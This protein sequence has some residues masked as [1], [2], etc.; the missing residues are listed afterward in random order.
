MPYDKPRNPGMGTAGITWGSAQDCLSAVLTDLKSWEAYH[1]TAEQCTIKLDYR[2]LARF[3]QR[4]AEKNAYEYEKLMKCTADKPFGISTTINYTDI[5][6][7]ADNANYTAD[8]LMQH[9]D[10]WYK[11]LWDSRTLLT[12]AAYYLSDQHEVTLYKKMCCYIDRVEN[13][14]WAVGV[15]KDRLTP[16]NWNHPDTYSV[17]YK[18]H[19]YF[20]DEYDVKCDIDFDI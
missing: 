7:A 5:A 14:C 12:D 9:L 4:M 10:M 3:H 1:Y 17:F 15:L 13:E 16:S 6:K 11:A 20:H 8:Q 18:L 19:K 2:G